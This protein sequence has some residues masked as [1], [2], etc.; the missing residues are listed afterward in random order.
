MRALGISSD[1][2]IVETVLLDIDDEN[3][4]YLNDFVPCIHDAG[5]L[6][7]QDQCI[8]YIGYL[9][10]QKT[11]YSAHKILCDYLLPHLGEMNYT[12]KAHFVGHM[13]M[14]LLRVM[15]NEIPETDRDHFKYKR[16]ETSG[17]LMFQL[18]KEYLNIQY[19]EIFQKIDKEYYYHTGTYEQDYQ[20]LIYNN[21]PFIFSRPNS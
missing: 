3:D 17:D 16:V 2:K 20:S 14:Q 12:K 4:H 15:H 19:K 5:E 21:Y 18:F 9:T 11:K 1:K 6:F 7:T 8:R 13:V 10:K